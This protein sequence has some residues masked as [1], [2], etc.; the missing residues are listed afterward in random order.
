MIRRSVRLT[1]MAVAG[2]VLPATV[3]AQAPQGNASPLLR[4]ASPSYVT[5]GT[6][7]VQVNLH[8]EG[9]A[10]GAVAQFGSQARPT[11]VVNARLVQVSLTAADLA[12]ARTVSIS[13][14]NP[15]AGGPVS[16]TLSFEIRGPTITAPPPSSPQAPAEVAPTITSVEPSTLTLFQGVN[17]RVLGQ[18]FTPTTRFRFGTSEF[19]PTMVDVRSATEI[20][21][22][23]RGG[24]LDREGT[25]NVTVATT[26]PSGTVKVSNSVPVRIQ[27]PPGPVIT[28]LEPNT[29]VAGTNTGLRIRGQNFTSS[30]EIR[31]D[32]STLDPQVVHFVSANELAVFFGGAYFTLDRPTISVRIVNRLTNGTVQT[33]EPA[34][35]RVTSP[36]A[37]APPEAPSIVGMTP[38]IAPVGASPIRLSVRGSSFAAGAVVRWDGQPLITRVLSA[39]ALE[40]DV[41]AAR[42]SIAGAHAVTVTDAAGSASSSLTF[43]VAELTPTISSVDPS[44]L[45]AGGGNTVFRIRGEYFTPTSR[46]RWGTSTLDAATVSVVSANELSVTA[47]RSHLATPGTANITVANTYPSGSTR[48]SNPVAVQLTPPPRPVVAA[49]EP[50]TVTAGGNSFILRITGRDF[51]PTVQVRFGGSTL[52][53]SRTQTNSLTEILAAVDAPFIAQPGTYRVEVVNIGATSMLVSN[54]VTITVTAPPPP[55]LPQPN[56]IPALTSVKVDTVGTLSL[57]GVTTPRLMLTLTGTGFM[58]G[59]VI[60]LNG[61]DATPIFDSSTQLRLRV[62]RIDRFPKPLPISVFNPLP[63]GGLSG[64][65]SLNW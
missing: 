17:F 35:I 22:D 55:P 57:N 25:V 14:R 45:I 52:D 50:S 29:V 64:P 9:F 49:L 59:S 6:G 44:T 10:S 24:Y 3:S 31:L 15:G 42:L 34:T 26:Y 20:V 60:R 33:S 46:V 7:P 51:A 54:S 58:Q 47:I 5:A 8:G 27:N 18:N 48:V 21:A 39:S 19:E 23:L 40:A 32:A 61:S 38:S 4:S 62:D 16:N 13:V 30:S 65:L 41:P 28:A 56:P 11:K 43:R 2:A 1:I 53:E 37:N 12:T 36:S 63:G